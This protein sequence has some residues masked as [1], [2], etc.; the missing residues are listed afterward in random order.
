MIR[1]ADLRVRQGRLE[2]AAQLLDGLDR[3]PRRYER[4]DIAVDRADRDLEVR[5]QLLRGELP[6]H[7][8]Q[9]QK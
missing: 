2:E 5:R 1:L 3:H 7:L 4:L 8:Q 6:A 9:E